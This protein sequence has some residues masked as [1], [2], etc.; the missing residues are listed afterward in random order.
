MNA[1]TIAAPVT[2]TAH[3]IDRWQT[4][5]TGCVNGHLVE[6][7]E[8]KFKG[9]TDYSARVNGQVWFTALPKGEAEKKLRQLRKGG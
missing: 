1:L 5:Y 4:Q 8:T 9:S 6:I 3:Q 7:L 2:F